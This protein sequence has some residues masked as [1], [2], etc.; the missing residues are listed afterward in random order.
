MITNY[1]LYN[2]SLRDKLKGKS[3]DE[4]I[5]SLEK[6]SDKNKI[7]KILNY[8]LSYDLLPD[9]LTFDGDM[10]YRNDYLPSILPE[11][12]TINGDLSCYDL[13]KLPDNLTI[14]GNLWCN[15]NKLTKLPDNLV[16]YGSIYCNNNKLIDLPDDLIVRGDLNCKNN[17]FPK[18]I[19]K[20][21]GVKG[22]FYK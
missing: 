4:L 3:Q 8:N 9:N 15:N 17:K 6:L 20:P 13:I 2:E 16:V 14:K 10:D 12:F 22:Y 1:K 19:E 5:K 11:N 21:T 18:D 7:L